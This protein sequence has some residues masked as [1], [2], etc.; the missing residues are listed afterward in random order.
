MDLGLNTK[1]SD[2]IFNLQFN[3]DTADKSLVADRRANL[4]V[5]WSRDFW[6]ISASG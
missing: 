3:T 2:V 4:I 1:M 5:F 6:T